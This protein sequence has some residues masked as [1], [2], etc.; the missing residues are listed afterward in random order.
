MHTSAV[1]AFRKLSRLV[2]APAGDRYARRAARGVPQPSVCFLEHLS[3]RPRSGQ[4]LLCGTSR[5]RAI[6][7][8]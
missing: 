7:R 8:D 5:L 1:S 4:P 3:E 6:D 2:A